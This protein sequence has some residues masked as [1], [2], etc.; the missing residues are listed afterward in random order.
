MTASLS[1]LTTVPVFL[2][3]RRVAGLWAGVFAGALIALSPTY[4]E[5]AHLAISDVPSGFFAG[6]TLLFVARLLDGETLRDYLLAGVAAALAAASKY[7]A[8][9]CAAAIVGIWIYWRVRRRDFNSLLIW[10]GLASVTTLLVVMPALWLR[11]ESVFGEPGDSDILFGYRQYAGRGWIGVVVESNVL[12]YA[13]GLAAAFGVV[14]LLA[15]IV[16]V[17]L[18]P[19]DKRR[20]LVVL[21]IYPLTFLALLIAMNVVVKRNMQPLLPAIALV[22][23]AGLSAWPFRITRL[24][25]GSRIALLS[26]LCLAQPAFETVAWDISRTRPGTR[27]LALKWIDENVPQGAAFVKEAYTPA[28]HFKRYAVRQS[29]YAARLALDEIRDPQWDYLLLARN[30][31]L[32]FLNPDTRLYEH[33]EVYAQRYERIFEEFELVQRFSPG[34]FRS[35]PDLLLYRIDPAEPRFADQRS[36]SLADIT[37][38]SDT[39]LRPAEGGSVINFFR[40]GQSVVFKEYLRAGRY[41]AGLNRQPVG[42]EGWLYVVSRDNH[43]IGQFALSSTFV[44]ELVLDRADKYL[45]RVFLSP[46]GELRSMDL[47]YIADN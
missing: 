27:E 20:R 6:L 35:G 15:G 36:F 8:G 5:V 17:F 12:Y 42:V 24:T 9:V 31:H 29:R 2:A 34:R 13:Q 44:T 47:T 30:A 38:V 33:H 18:L 21:A 41:R 46:G 43:E 25:E 7:P 10:S 26:V 11:F 4:N 22:L 3:G 37:W 19:R 39:A 28:L 40:K 23:G 16:G 45:F 32:R 14:A 1:A